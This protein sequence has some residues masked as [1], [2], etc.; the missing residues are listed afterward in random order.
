MI[1]NVVWGTVLVAVAYFGWQIFLRSLPVVIQ[2]GVML[3]AT[4]VGWVLWMALLE[5]RRF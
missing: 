4:L 1:Q 2:L 5:I 3:L